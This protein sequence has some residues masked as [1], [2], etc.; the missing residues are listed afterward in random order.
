MS[1]EAPPPIPPSTGLTPLS[2]GPIPLSPAAAILSAAAV[3]LGTLF[4]GIG[5][6]IIASAVANVAVPPGAISF[7]QASLI[8]APD[9]AIAEQTAASVTLEHG[10]VWIEFTSLASGFLTALQRVETLAEGMQAQYPQLAAASDPA[11][12]DTPTEARGSVDR[13][14]GRDSDRSGRVRGRWRPG[15]G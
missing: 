4:I 15:G 3:L 1:A 8:P 10:G 11:P 12:F 7:G 6:P 2:S 14:G 13:P 5:L 9:W